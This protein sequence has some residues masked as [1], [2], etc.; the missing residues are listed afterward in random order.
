ME[1]DQKN[2]W[3]AG[4]HRM[5][6]YHSLFFFW[7]RKHVELALSDECEIACMR[8]WSL[9]VGVTAKESDAFPS[10]KTRIYKNSFECQIVFIGL[11]PRLP[12]S[13]LS[14]DKI[15]SRWMVPI[16]SPSWVVRLTPWSEA[17]LVMTSPARP[18]S[19]LRTQ[20]SKALSLCSHNR[21]KI[22]RK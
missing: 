21:I 17:L 7:K 9:Y 15:I 16:S 19:L 5:G 11:L 10:R 4:V 8:T 20:P 12:F 14:I 3:V 2:S 13:P 6:K 1:Q 22:P 18:L